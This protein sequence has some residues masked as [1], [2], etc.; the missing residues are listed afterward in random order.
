[1]WGHIEKRDAEQEMCVIEKKSQGGQGSWQIKG[2]VIRARL[3]LF[4][5][6]ST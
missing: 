1:M 4:Q 5:G 6:L 2:M 3:K